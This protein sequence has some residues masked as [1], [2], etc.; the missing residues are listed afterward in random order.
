MGVTGLL[1]FKQTL[2]ACNG[3]SSCWCKNGNELS[4]VFAQYSRKQIVRKRINEL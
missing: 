2:M 4:M 3:K 1:K